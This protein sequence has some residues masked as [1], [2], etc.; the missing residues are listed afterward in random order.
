MV[1]IRNVKEVFSDR[2]C[3][4]FLDKPV[5][6]IL[7]KEIYNIAKLGPTSANCCPLRI[8]FVQSSVGKDKFRK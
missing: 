5:D 4:K 7:L 8:V 3:Y 2:T 6:K 1:L